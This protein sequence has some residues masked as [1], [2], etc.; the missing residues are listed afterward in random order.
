MSFDAIS[1]A[2]AQPINKSSTKFILVAL[3]NCVNNGMSEMLCWPSISH[4]AESTAQNRKTVLAGIKRLCEL[5]YLQDTGQ[6]CGVTKQVIIYRLNS[7]KNG[8]VKGDDFVAKSDVNA[9]SNSPE[10]GIVSI[11]TVPFLPTNSTAFTCEQSLKRD[12]EPVK[13][14]VKEPV[15]KKERKSAYAPPLP[16]ALLAD[17]LC[18]RKAKRAG[19]ITQTVM[20]GIEREANKAGISL[21]DA[22][23]FCCESGWQSF[24]SEWYE[25]RTACTK[26]ATSARQ[27]QSFRE[28]DECARHKAFEEM[29]GRK[30][31]PENAH[32]LVPVDITSKRLPP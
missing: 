23:T 2:I 21:I 3:A 20:A 30:W 13:E 28:R 32:G 7:T 4:L 1:W 31:E 14:P 11:E 29:T 15:I 16:E 9:L 6:R 25:Q 10:I 12:T 26:T 8:T 17:F 5:G 24:K 18:V 27:T 19:P 22:V